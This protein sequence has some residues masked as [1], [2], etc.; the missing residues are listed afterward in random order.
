MVLKIKKG[1]RILR[2]FFIEFFQDPIIVNASLS[3]KNNKEI[4]HSN[5]GDDINFFFIKEISAKKII[6]YHECLLTK[7]AKRKNYIII[8][9]T[10]EMLTNNQSIIWG[11]GLMNENPP[12]I[13]KPQ[14]ICAVRGPKTREILLKNGIECPAIYGDPALLLPLFYQPSKE[15]KYKIGIIPHY[16]DISFIPP[17]ILHNPNVHLIK[18][19]EYSNW[20]DFIKEINSCEYVISSSLHGLI[21]SEAYNIPNRWIEI[22][23]KNK[24]SH[25]KYDDFYASI[26]KQTTPYIIKSDTTIKSLLE[27][28]Q[29]WHSGII[30][31]TPLLE[32]CPFKL[33][34]LIKDKAYEKNCN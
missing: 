10:I 33:K 22:Q 21:V 17:H 12:K 19:K 28:C 8:G 25:F 18:V 26:G 4:Y 29:K 11:A 3:I 27:E 20:L 14:N 15:K 23:N 31:L 34:Q 1:L 30:N 5:W 24:R 6:L 9:S 2:N 16:V 32:A 7:I 13:V